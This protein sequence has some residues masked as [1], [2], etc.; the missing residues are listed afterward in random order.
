MNLCHLFD[1]SLTGRRDTIALEFQDRSYTFG[2]LDSR[3]NRVAQLLLYTIWLPE[4]YHTACRAS[5]FAFATSSGRFIA[6]GVTFLVGSGVAHY[7]TIGTPVAFTSLAF[8]LG[9]LL[10]PL[11]KETKG[12]P[13]PE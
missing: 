3:S 6:A 12:K 2:E 9:L 11:G 1:L 8:A 13:L 10:L 5:A 7:G 4:Q